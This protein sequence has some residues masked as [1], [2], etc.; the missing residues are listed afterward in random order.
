MRRRSKN[1]LMDKAIAI[2]KGRGAANYAL[3]ALG[4]SSSSIGQD[5]RTT[6]LLAEAANNEDEEKFVKKKTSNKAN[7]KSK[8]LSITDMLLA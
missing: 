1:E 6:M 8:V 3:V 7:Q 4:S 5:S 2:A